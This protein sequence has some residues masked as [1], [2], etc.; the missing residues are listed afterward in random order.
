MSIYI[1]QEQSSKRDDFRQIATGKGKYDVL[2]EHWRVGDFIITHEC[3]RDG[4][5]LLDMTSY[6]RFYH[7]DQRS[8]WRASSNISRTFDEAVLLALGKKY[9]GLNNQFA[10]YASRMLDIETNKHD[11]WS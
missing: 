10:E 2:I 8:T 1:G 4:T 11:Q 6:Y 7:P 3:Q 5:D 9:L